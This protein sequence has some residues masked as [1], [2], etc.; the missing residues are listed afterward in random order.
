[1]GTN[2]EE[3]AQ[4]SDEASTRLNDLLRPPPSVAIM[5]PHGRL[6]REAAREAAAAKNK[7]SAKA[8]AKP[9]GAAA[10]TSTRNPQPAAHGMQHAHT[11]PHAPT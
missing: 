10:H 1:M 6:Q 9:S 11:R 2:G 3:H 4:R 7:A 8:K 5:G